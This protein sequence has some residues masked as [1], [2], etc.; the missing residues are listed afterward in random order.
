MAVLRA[1]GVVERRREGARQYYRLSDP[2]IA[3]ACGL[4]S[5][6][7]GEIAKA[8]RER[9]APVARDAPSR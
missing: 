8:E 4:M 3:R 2:K 9:L 5:E 1:A 6:I 7:V